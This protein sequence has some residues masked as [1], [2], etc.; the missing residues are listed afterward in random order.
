MRFAEVVRGVESGGEEGRD[1]AEDFTVHE[2]GSFLFAHGDGEDGL[3]Q[4]AC[5]GRG[6]A[7]KGTREGV[8]LGGGDLLVS[9]A[10]VLGS[11][12]HRRRCYSCWMTGHG[13]R[14]VVSGT[15]R[16]AEG[17]TRGFAVVNDLYVVLST[18]SHTARVMTPLKEAMGVGQW[19]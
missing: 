13:R 14:C 7:G 3:E 18:Y 5:W 1:S 16:V 11:C 4:G 17:A 19:A 2:E 12:W 9:A 8:L 10:L 6:A 15:G